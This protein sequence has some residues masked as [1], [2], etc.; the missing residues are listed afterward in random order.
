MRKLNTSDVFAMA[1][2]I[3]ASGVRGELRP[4][5]KQAVESESTL[6]DIG[7]DG[8]LMI[9]EALAERKAENAIYEAL[10]GPLEVSAGEVADIPLLD[11]VERL[12]TLAEENDLKRF[13]G[14]VSGI[15][16]KN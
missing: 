4:L 11:M 3:R 6:E 7:I 15:L 9:F 13:F 12:K 8:I 16:G 14:Y 10:A 2:I 1:R 5:I